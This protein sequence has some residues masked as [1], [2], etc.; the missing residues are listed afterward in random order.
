MEELE[1][2]E[3]LLQ[4]AQYDITGIVISYDGSNHAYAEG[5]AFTN[6]TFETAE[7]I[8]DNIDPWGDQ[9]KLVAFNDEVLKRKVE[10]YFDEVLAD[11]IEADWSDDGGY[12]T[13]AIM[14]PSGEMYIN[15]IV[16]VTRTENYIC[17]GNMITGKTDIFRAII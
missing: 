15:S 16:R 7:D 1:L 10:H 2:M 14:V 9:S 12:G 11:N 13:V 5:V 8:Y 6:G 17:K 4:A 3:L